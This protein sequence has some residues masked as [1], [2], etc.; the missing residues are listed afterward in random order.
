MRLKDGFITHESNGE[1]ILV[2]ADAGVFSGLV[3]S[4][5]TA[6][7]IIEQLKAETTKERILAAME[8]RFDGPRDRMAADIDKV[9][10]GLR[11]IGAIEE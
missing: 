10:A 5:R 6:A 7:F 9:V 4:N 11:R 3:R 8:E 2:S 1:Q